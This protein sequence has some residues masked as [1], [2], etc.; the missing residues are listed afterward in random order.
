MFVNPHA[1]EVNLKIVYAGAPWERVQA[2]VEL[3]AAKTAG[4]AS[5]SKNGKLVVAPRGGVYFCDFD[6]QIK[7][8]P[9]HG[10][11]L[12]VYAFEEDAFGDAA[13]AAMTG[14]DAM[15][16]VAA[17]DTAIARTRW[18]TLERDLD[19]PGLGR[20]PLV[21]Q[22]PEGADERMVR[23][24]LGISDEV[25]A[26]IADPKGAG[27]FDVLKKATALAITAARAAR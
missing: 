13:R 9:D 4:T 7:P 11:R 19:A 24:E 8:W 2:T 12:H 10:L 16:F 21:V 3:I 20:V 23:S 1:R 15:V 5:A 6:P 27:V 25:P 14:A 26:L 17:P 18:Q 22:M